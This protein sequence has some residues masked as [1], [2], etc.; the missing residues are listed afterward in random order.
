VSQEGLNAAVAQATRYTKIKIFS[1]AVA[2]RRDAGLR[3]ESIPVFR[4]LI[5]SDKADRDHRYH[6]QL[7]Y[8]LKDKS[9][10]GWEA[11]EQELSKAIEVRDRIGNTGFGIYEFNRAI[12]RIHLQRAKEDIIADFTKSTTDPRRTRTLKDAK[13]QEWLRQHNLSFENLVFQ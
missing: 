4:A 5:E 7:A 1:D 12:C 10:P 8:A 6:G 13:A 9:R 3:D 2:A 11:A